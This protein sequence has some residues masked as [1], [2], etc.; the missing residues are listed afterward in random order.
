MQRRQE[1]H[2]VIAQA[3]EELYAE[4]LTE[5]YE[6]LAYHFY[7][8]EDWAKA[9]EYLLKAAQ[10]AAQTFAN[11]EAAALYEQAAETMVHLGVGVDSCTRLSVYQAQLSI[12]IALS[13]FER[14]IVA[15][16]RAAALAREIGDRV[17]EAA[18]L[19]GLG[20]A[21][22]WGQHHLDAAVDY[23]SRA[24]EIGEAEGAL[25][26][27]ASAH[28]A[29]GQV[30]AVTGRFVEARVHFEQAHEIGQRARDGA[31]QA[32]SLGSMGILHNWAGEYRE[33]VELASE[34]LRL[35]REV[36]QVVPLALVLWLASLPRIGQGD[37]EEARTLLEE[38]LVFCEKAG[39]QVMALR[40]ANTLG[41]MW[42]ECGDLTRAAELNARAADG[43]RKRGDPETTANPEL[44]LADISIAQGD[45]GLAGELL[46]GVQALVRAP[47]TS[48]WMRWRYSTH[49][50]ASLADL[51]FARGDHAAAEARAAECLEL[52]T[53][54]QS[55]KYVVRGWRVR[56]QIALAERRW[57]AAEHALGEAITVARLIR[58]PTQLWRTAV[59]LARL[60][61]ACG[62]DDQASA[63]RDEA[64]RVIEGRRE[65]TSN[66]EI[67]T[68]LTSL[69]ARIG[70]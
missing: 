38:G 70:S 57:N 1:L 47:S 25:A 18:A 61:A 17:A 8:A 9:F 60:H 67:R 39:E 5:H 27:V 7:R 62:R 20:W 29:I 32:I 6:V 55:R 40:M 14:A 46:E 15:G 50:L 28:V 21:A 16:E 43:A 12:Y 48:E 56:G 34:G 4:R 31:T 33:A 66:P 13:E 54:K 36:Q 10:K 11:R 63:D 53:L 49:L 69:L 22:T 51:A 23:A 24:I 59:E 42:M 64:R 30:M 26:P 52:A 37:Y 19:V 65:H 41:W 58:N 44:N 45:L 35:A 3:V 68:A 2:R